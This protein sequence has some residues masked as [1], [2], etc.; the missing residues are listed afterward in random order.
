MVWIIGGVII[1]VIL[2]S[3]FPKQAVWI[4]AGVA[5]A[6]GT[7]IFYFVEES[8]KQADLEKQ[9]ADR[10]AREFALI[11]VAAD[12]DATACPDI[13]LPI[14]VTI[15]NASPDKT[16]KAVTFNLEGHRRGFSSIVSSARNLVSDKIIEPQGS[17][18][19]CWPLPAYSS[20][21]DGV[22]PRMLQWNTIKQ[23]VAWM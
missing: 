16:M 8:R 21:P 15:R 18:T 1:L 19:S 10:R 5:V 17:Y 3:A 11:E 22:T 7:S 6:A 4:V 9:V 2:L 20:L 13:R 14:A 23:T 12:G